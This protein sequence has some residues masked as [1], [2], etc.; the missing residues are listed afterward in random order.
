MYEQQVEA[1]TGGLARAG[2]GWRSGYDDA[3]TASAHGRPC[4]EAIALHDA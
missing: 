4:A 3:A 1:R 2:T